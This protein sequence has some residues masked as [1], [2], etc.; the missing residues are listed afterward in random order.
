MQGAKE[1]DSDRSQVPLQG[2]GV[3]VIVATFIILLLPLIDV[4]LRL[5]M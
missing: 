1:Q 3:I 2:S 5:V 4:L